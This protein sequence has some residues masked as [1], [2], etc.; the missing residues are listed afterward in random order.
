[1]PLAFLA[2]FVPASTP[3]YIGPGGGLSALGALI[4]LIAVVILAF[5]GFVW[6]PIKRLRRKFRPGQPKG[7][8]QRDATESAAGPPQA[9]VSEQPASAPRE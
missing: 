6:Y 3:A 9:N 7:V 5:I 8:S 1:M 2:L 4:A